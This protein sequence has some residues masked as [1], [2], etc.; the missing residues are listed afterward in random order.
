MA[1]REHICSVCT[2]I[3]FVQVC[4]SECKLDVFIPTYLRVNVLQGMHC[5]RVSILCVYISLTLSACLC[6]CVS[7]CLCV[8]TVMKQERLLGD[9]SIIFPPGPRCPQRSAALSRWHWAHFGLEKWCIRP[10][11][12]HHHHQPPSF[13]Q[14]TSQLR[15][16]S[17]NPS[18]SLRLPF[19]PSAL[20][21][22]STGTDF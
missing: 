11:R 1:L 21:T 16:R 18:N 6:L 7:V 9:S 8:Y 14:P 15:R 4:V 2:C 20:H 22:V 5:H 12:H 3:L 13:L 10:Q 19:P 17:N